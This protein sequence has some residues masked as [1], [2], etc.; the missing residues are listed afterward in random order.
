MSEEELNRKQ[1]GPADPAEDQGPSGRSAEGLE[2]VRSALNHDLRTPLTIIVS[3][4]QTLAQ[5][6]VG[7]LNERQK[8]MLEVMV[9][10]CFRMDALIRELVGLLRDALEG[11]R[12]D[13]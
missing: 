2:K 10:E 13:C 11:G 12:C 9:K 4:A 3:Y 5:G 6:K 7:E 1:K 8:E